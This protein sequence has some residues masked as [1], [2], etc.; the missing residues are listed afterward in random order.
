VSSKIKR[1]SHGAW[2]RTAKGNSR[3][4]ENQRWVRKV[5]QYR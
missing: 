5:Y 3:A 2:E 1:C 4:A